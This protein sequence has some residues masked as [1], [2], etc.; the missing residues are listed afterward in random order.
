MLN[1]ELC[2][3]NESGMFVTVFYGVLH[4][5]T[6]EIQYSNGGHN[7]PYL[8]SLT[9]HAQ[10]VENTGGMALGVMEMRDMR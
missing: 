6:G 4:L 5:R 1:N 9:G 8:L 3:D 7:L 10:F 2:R